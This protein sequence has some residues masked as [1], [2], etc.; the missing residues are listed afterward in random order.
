M[1]SR[2]SLNTSP[3][4]AIPPLAIT[5][6]GDRFYL[7]T[8]PHRTIVAEVL[9]RKSYRAATIASVLA[10]APDLLAV[11]EA[12]WTWRWSPE[13]YDALTISAVP[14]LDDLDAALA[15]AR[16]VGAPHGT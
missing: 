1:D 5:A 9:D 16:T 2:P 10:A 8:G 15:K 3:R 7:R 12:I 11:C 6:A 14:W 4:P 13:G